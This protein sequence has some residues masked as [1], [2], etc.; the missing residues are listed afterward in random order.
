MEKLQ[1]SQDRSKHAEA[2]STPAERRP[3]VVERPLIVALNGR[4]HDSDA[5]A[6]GRTLQTA[7]GGWL[8]IAHVIPPAPLGRGMTEYALL[9]RQEGRELLARAAEASGVAAQTRLLET[10]P[11]AW[12]LAEL[13]EDHDAG[14]LVLGSSHRG[15][16]GS[17]V[18]GRTASHLV[19]RTPCP[20]AVAPAGYASA[21]ATSIST[22]GVAYD[23]TSTADLAL[24][25]AVGGASKLAVPLRLYHAIHRIP[26]DPSWDLF[27]RNM[28]RIAQ[29]ILARGLQQVPG[30]IAATSVLLEGDVSEV[31]AEA[32]MSEDV[33]LLYVGSRGYGPLREALVAGT[34]GGL[35]HTA[36]VALVIVPARS[37]G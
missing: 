12:A 2:Q 10:W 16:V 15:S 19:A 5:L 30:D 21:A 32:A 35:L 23:G 34:V 1:V 37:H 26:D 8:L 11:A 27:R 29:Q 9:A 6:L 4:M 33:G 28:H 25:A 20:I 13:A 3:Q 7:L 22:I 24:A 36:R 18:P 17:V 14:M 31:I